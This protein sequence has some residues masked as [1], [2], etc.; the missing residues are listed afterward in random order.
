MGGPEV[1]G[2][3]QPIGEPLASQDGRAKT[4]V[5]KDLPD[6]SHAS[7]SEEPHLAV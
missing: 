3:G 5:L 1:L 2:C 7:T 4:V 6:A